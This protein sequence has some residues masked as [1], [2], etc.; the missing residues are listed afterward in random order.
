M[1]LLGFRALWPYHSHGG[2][3]VLESS[4]FEGV[5]FADCEV[6]VD[7][8]VREGGELVGEAG[9]VFSGHVGCECVAV[10][11]LLDLFVH[12]ILS[13]SGED[14]VNVVVAASHNLKPDSLG[15]ND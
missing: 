14:D 5:V 10:V 7:Q 4:V 6:N 12:H 13:R 8:F 3:V 2:E 11:L 15:S 1:N 9:L